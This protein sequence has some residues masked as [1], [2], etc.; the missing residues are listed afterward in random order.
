M[1]DLGPP[2]DL[3]LDL[4]VERLSHG[5]EGIA[6][7]PDGR[8]VFIAGAL[9]G[10]V[11]RARVD[12]QKRRFARAQLVSVL[13][14]SPAR[15][16]PQCPLAARCGG[17]QLWHVAPALELELK[18]QAAR[19]AIERVSRRS[20]AMPEATLHASPS[21]QRY[22]CRAT[23]H[24]RGAGAQRR[25]GF[26]EGQSHRILTLPSC[27]VLTSALE[28]A[29][30]ELSWAMPSLAQAELLC[31]EASPGRVVVTAQAE[32]AL[33]PL[34]PEAQRW[35]ERSQVVQGVVLS[36][37]GQAAQH[38]GAVQIP[39]SVALAQAPAALADEHVPAG[40]FRQANP[41]VNQIMAQ[42]LRRLVERSGCRDMVELFCGCGN[43]S[44]GLA[45]GLERLRAY[46]GQGQSVQAARR[47]AARHPQLPLTFEVADL[48]GEGAA[49][50]FSRTSFEGVQ[51]VVLD[52]PRA[53]ARELCQLLADAAPG[54]LRD[55]FY[56]SCDPACLGRDLA[57]LGPQWRIEALH[58]FDMFPRTAHIETLV[59]LRRGES[60]GR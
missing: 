58:M 39:A 44:F 4:Q 35:L 52:P 37:R 51:G 9:P 24:L 2:R 14:A 50:W 55:L 23:F 53:G 26:H 59:W 27:L 56:I 41:E 6:R 13:L 60:S 17:C 30:E 16:Q 18:A 29:Y 5:A 42:T 38:V 45:Q 7:A 10:E 25:V 48:M 22:R 31:E 19:E 3:E 49:R 33:A 47:L 36:A 34:R 15:V 54:T 40:L 43:L 8:V 12:R 20:H 21:Q 46:E 28:L 1:S 57:E 11:V 32:Q